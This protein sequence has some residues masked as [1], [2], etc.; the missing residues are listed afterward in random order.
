MPKNGVKPMFSTSESVMAWGCGDASADCILQVGERLD[1]L[2]AQIS[3][4]TSSTVSPVPAGLCPG[5]APGRI[6]PACR[7]GSASWL[8]R[9]SESIARRSTETRI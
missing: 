4:K 6:P 3:A 7:D 2:L 1:P 5:I 9:S 8:T